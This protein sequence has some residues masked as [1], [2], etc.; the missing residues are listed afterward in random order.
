MTPKTCNHT[1][2]EPYIRGPNI[3]KCRACVK[4]ESDKKSYDKRRDAILAQKKIYGLV[5]KEQISH[6][7][8]LY[9]DSL[10]EEVREARLKRAKDYYDNNREKWEGC[11]PDKE[12]R[13]LAYHRRMSDP[14]AKEME[15]LRNAVRCYVYRKDSIIKKKDTLGEVI[16]GITRDK[17]WD[18]LRKTF[19]A[20]YGRDYEEDRDNVHIDHII[21]RSAANTVDEYRELL[22]YTNSQLLL[23]R[24]NMIKHARAKEDWEKRIVLGNLKLDESDDAS[25]SE[26]DSEDD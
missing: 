4:I 21:P 3:G 8:K 25:D 9:R 6:R 14:T 18:Y 1:N 11:V 12:M 10:P 17:Y 7:Q 26:N 13:K 24:D 19:K 23:A 15:R 20:N 22:H 2:Q 5:N 16:L